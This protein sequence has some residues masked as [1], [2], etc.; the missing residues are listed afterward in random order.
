MKKFLTA[1]FVIGLTAC[2]QSQP[3]GET[4]T[5]DFGEFTIETPNTWKQIKAKGIDSYVGKI[6]IDDSD[7]LYFDLGW[8]SNDLSEYQEVNL[9]DNK[10][11]YISSNDTAYSPALVDS[12]NKEKVGQARLHA[13]VK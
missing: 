5:M 8:Y 6:A 3:K 11:Y 10:T 4:K 2:N 1:I 13:Y 9:A 7:I 12:S